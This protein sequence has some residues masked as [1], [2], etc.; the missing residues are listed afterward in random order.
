MLSAAGCVALGTTD[1]VR[2]LQIFGGYSVDLL[3]LDFVLPELDGG[4]VTHAMK[5]YEPNVPIICLQAL[6]CPTNASPL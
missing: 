1:G 4:S 3:L 2:A 6:K 5:E